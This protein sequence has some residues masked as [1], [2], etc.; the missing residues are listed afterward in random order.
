MTPDRLAWSDSTSAGETLGRGYLRV[1]AA[2]AVE[3]PASLEMKDKDDSLVLF[4]AAL[5]RGNAEFL[6]AIE[7]E[8]IIIPFL[9]FRTPWMLLVDSVYPRLLNE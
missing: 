1:V 7:Q 6:S 5:E 9:Q 4:R 2:L 8:K 3:L